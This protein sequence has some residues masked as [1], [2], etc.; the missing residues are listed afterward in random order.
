MFSIPIPIRW[1]T[2]RWF[3]TFFAWRQRVLD[4]VLTHMYERPMRLLPADHVAIAGATVFWMMR[5]GARHLIMLRSKQH[6]GG[7]LYLPSCVGTGSHPDMAH[8]MREALVRT[9]GLS[10]VST[11]PLS[12]IATDKVAAAPMYPIVDAS[13][14]ETRVQALMWVVPI[15]P[16]Q[17]ELIR[18]APNVDMRIVEENIRSNFGMPEVSPAHMELL[19][20]IRRALPSKKALYVDPAPETDREERMA[21]EA[22]KSSGRIVH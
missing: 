17:L 6:H 4:R 11:L 22:Q 1:G 15:Q 3:Q 13:G 8:A 20:S 5:D 18:L 16:I 2:A 7:M 19:R 14:I 10:F 9:F 21:E 12:Q